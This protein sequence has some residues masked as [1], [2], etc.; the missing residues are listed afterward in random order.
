MSRSRGDIKIM[1]EN[2][3]AKVSVSVSK[4]T[5]YLIYGSDAGSKYNKAIA[6]KIDV[7]S[8]NEMR[9]KLE[10]NNET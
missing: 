1:L 5:D 10:N 9:D 3:G 2:L 4:K 7:L 6:L 8:E